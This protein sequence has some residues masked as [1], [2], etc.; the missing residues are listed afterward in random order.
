MSEIYR[1]MRLER[2][3]MPLV[4]TGMPLRPPGRSEVRIRVAACAVC[5]TDLHVVDGELPTCKHPIVPGHEIIGHVEAVG[6]GV[7]T[8]AEGDRV[9]VPWLGWTCGTCDA[10]RRGEENLCS[11]ARFTGC[12]IDGGFAEIAYADAR[13]VFSIP[14][15]YSDSEAAPLMC[16][17]L[18]GWR[19]LKMAGKGKRLGLYGFGA[20]AHIAIQVAR[21]QNQD[22]Y[23]FVRPRDKK[24][25]EFA[26]RMG[27]AWA[28][29]ADS[30]APE[31]LDAAIIFAPVGALVPKA[32]SAVRPGGIVVC[33][34]IHM[35]DIPSFPY[36]LLWQE[37]HLRSVANLTRHDAEEF[38][39]LAP[40]I[41][42]HCETID[43]ELNRANEALG[44]LSEG[45]LSGAA[46]LIP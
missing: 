35:S 34:G 39:E 42:V 17:G 7:K 38:L 32:L 46:V 22:V 18:I 37:R 8:L 1:A 24:A 43:Y 31:V 19:A 26:R 9:G 29:D 15:S 21:H 41:P 5:R 30:Q 16:A 14:K 20:A 4:E 11:H 6:A 27:A 10:C 45:R 36:S 13:Y 28:G 44:D 23:A 3:G 33:G 12:H 2:P 25:S 40:D